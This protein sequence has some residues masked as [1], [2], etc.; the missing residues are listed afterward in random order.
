VHDEA[1]TAKHDN[2]AGE[3][4]SHQRRG[5]SIPPH[6]SPVH[7]Q[8]GQPAGIYT[9]YMPAALSGPGQQEDKVRAARAGFDRHFTKPVHLNALRVFL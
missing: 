7:R 8:I 3:A 9:Q 6:V 5:K 1:V 2:A 4:W